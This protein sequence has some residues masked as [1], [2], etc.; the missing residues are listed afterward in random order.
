[1]SLI[2]YE[3][4]QRSRD[5][6]SRILVAGSRKYPTIQSAIDALPPT[7]GEVYVRP[8][9]YVEAV[10]MNKPNTI[11]RGTWDSIVKMPDN[12]IKW[13]TDSPIRIF[14]DGC[15]V[16]GLRIDG[17]RQNNPH[18]DD[19]DLG[20]QADGV[21]IYAS[22][23]TV[24]NCWV[25][26][27]CGHGIIVWNFP[28]PWEGE[29][30]GELASGG[31]RSQVRILNN[32][33][34]RCPNR[35]NI[36]IASLWGG[37]TPPPQDKINHNCTISG[38][39][40]P[41]G[42][43]VLHTAN[44]CIITGNRAKF[45]SAHTHC[46]NVTVTDNIVGNIRILAVTDA[47]VANNNVGPYQEIYGIGVDRGSVHVV[48]SNN[49]VKDISGS[50]DT[51]GIKVINGNDVT[52]TGNFVMNSNYNIDAMNLNAVNVR[53]ENNTV[54]NGTKGILPGFGTVVRGNDIQGASVRGIERT[55]NEYH[56]VLVESNTI[57]NC[58]QGIR[59][60]SHGNVIRK[61]I[62]RDCELNGIEVM[63]KDN[64]ILDNRVH[65]E[66]A[67]FVGIQMHP[68]S[69]YEYEGTLVRGNLLDAPI[70]VGDRRIEATFRNNVGYVTEAQGIGSISEGMDS[71]EIPH[72]MDSKPD[73]VFITPQTS[74]MVWVSNITTSTFTVNRQGT[75]GE[76][77]FYW[78][79]EGR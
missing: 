14:A 42:N 32:R 70:P 46:R 2:Q 74:E 40:S 48:I 4:L 44:D 63:G 65:G 12:A 67:E 49:I 77:S 58:R 3:L 20:V 50:S 45:I 73:Y 5:P 21:S 68:S 19:T 43:I 38:N 35:A 36:D 69:I 57:S 29:R 31:A 8:G 6:D 26:D 53:I 62:I 37:G 79:A 52:I 13:E 56:N 17:N 72:G 28:F 64:A 9:L 55:G 23:V 76:T 24:K 27:C 71:V 61:N 1:M 15:V 18:L 39:F 30:A 11:L 54:R 10:Q 33:V 78:Y 60:L 47:I 75:S 59:F 25:H 66:G 16:D 22:N 7:G 41:D 51:A 34:E